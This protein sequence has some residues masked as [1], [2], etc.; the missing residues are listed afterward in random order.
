MG[1]SD[2]FK[3][4]RREQGDELG[5]GAG[6]SVGRLDVAVERKQA[7]STS[8]GDSTASHW[9]QRVLEGQRV[10]RAGARASGR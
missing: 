1:C 7:G 9:F 8:R 3:F 5:D 6:Q 2:I 4:L 10:G